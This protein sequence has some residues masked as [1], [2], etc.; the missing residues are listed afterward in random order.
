M[1]TFSAVFLLF[2]NISVS[3]EAIAGGKWAYCMFERG[4]KAIFPVLIQDIERLH[5]QT[6]KISGKVMQFRPNQ[7]GGG[8]ESTTFKPHAE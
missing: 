8:G 5:R 7:T 3:N 2:S 4:F 1:P 6:C